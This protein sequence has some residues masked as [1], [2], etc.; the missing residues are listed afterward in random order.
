MKK[1]LGILITL[2]LSITA[3]GVTSIPAS[4]QVSVS[5]RVG[6]VQL[7]SGW[8]ADVDY[9]CT[10]DESQQYSYS[11]SVSNAGWIGHVDPPPGM[12]FDPTTSHL[13]GIPTS[14]GTFNPFDSAGESCFVSFFDGVGL[15]TFSETVHPG[16]VQVS[17]RY[18]NA[19]GHSGSSVETLHAG[20][21]Y[22]IDY[23]CVDG[24]PA[25]DNV[26]T[27][28]SW[29]P[30]T[31]P[32]NMSFDPVTNHISGTPTNTGTFQLNDISCHI[33]SHGFSVDMTLGVGQISVLGDPIDPGPTPGPD[34]GNPPIDTSTITASGHISSSAEQTNVEAF[35]SYSYACRDDNP[36]SVNTV[37]TN[38]WDVEAWKPT[39]LI[40]DSST[41]TLYGIPSAAGNFPLP[42]ISCHVVANGVAVD[43]DIAAGSINVDQ[44]PP[45]TLNHS[46][47]TVGGHT[48]SSQEDLRTGWSYNLNYSCL[49]SNS[50]S[51]NTVTT[52]GWASTPALPE[53]MTFDSSTNTIQGTPTAAGYFLLPNMECRVSYLG[54]SD[55][56]LK[57]AGAISVTQ[58]T[59]PPVDPQPS[60]P[61]ATIHVTPMRDA[62]C[63]FAVD[64][65]YGSQHPADEG[66]PVLEIDSSYA[67]QVLTLNGKD[68]AF[69]GHDVL[70]FDDMSDGT[71]SSDNWT[72]SKP[73]G[74]NYRGFCGHYLTF[75]LTYKSD[76]ISSLPATA[77]HVNVSEALTDS[78]QVLRD[79]DQGKCGV[80]FEVDIAYEPDFNI[81]TDGPDALLYYEEYAPN[82][83]TAFQA[84]FNL[85]EPIYGSYAYFAFIPESRTLNEDWVETDTDGVELVSTIGS[86]L[87]CGAIAQAW[88]KYRF[89]GKRQG[90]STRVPALA[91]CGKGTWSVSGFD[92][93]LHPC[94]DATVGHYVSTKGA[95]EQIACPEGFTTEESGS[96]SPSDCF[97][98]I[99]QTVK[100]LSAL[101]GLKLKS[102]TGLP[103]LTDQGT[104]LK[105][106]ASGACTI[107]DVLVKGRRNYKITASK[108]AGICVL[109]LSAPSGYHMPALATTLNLKVSKTGK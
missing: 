61:A 54:V 12:T 106:I 76:D 73:G 36:N 107:S 105:I 59:P 25:S 84:I 19:G 20:T 1:I 69:Y 82:G 28:N 53:G 108:T 68:P 21:Y 86:P 40:F 88:T 22:D 2:V 57:S 49:D 94:E 41:W 102:V 14:T 23:N 9:S 91:K 58:S 65:F 100:K 17:E 72:F 27:T 48:S 11:Y 10:L 18:L 51:G 50:N 97:K 46:G 66:S 52:V 6:T 80:S 33:E 13:I 104:G 64:V 42:P 37:T 89:G 15:S 8:Y 56:Y 63:S 96:T 81:E 93:G 92:G 101:K 39:G 77:E 45:I 75:T 71:F 31:I 43:V 62:K 35:V 98:P 95:T 70:N 16:P 87:G 34:P 32:D 83:D 103:A 78:M 38:S 3:I 74:F 47:V 4:A 60:I 44:A 5:L 99:I 79:I 29:I 24:N 30:G 90:E 55:T 67:E 85:H 26:V 109:Q 7:Y